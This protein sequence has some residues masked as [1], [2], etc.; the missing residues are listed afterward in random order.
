ML[1]SHFRSDPDE[2]SSVSPCRISQ[3]LPQVA[4]VSPFQLILDN[5]DTFIRFGKNVH[6]ERTDSSLLFDEFQI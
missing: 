6:C 1:I 2:C 3:Q 5:H 4:V